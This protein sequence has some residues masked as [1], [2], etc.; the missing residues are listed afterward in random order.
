MRTL[1]T[2]W[3]IVV[4]IGLT[5]FSVSAAEPTNP[6]WYKRIYTELEDKRLFPLAKQL[7]DTEGFKVYP[8]KMGSGIVASDW[9]A[10]KSTKTGWQER[11][12]F[13]VHFRRHRVKKNTFQFTL[14]LVVEVLPPKATQWQNQRVDFYNHVFYRKTLDRMDE[15]VL[16]AG[17]KITRM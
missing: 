13:R 16:E 15:L 4:T 12:R 9:R 7:I 8:I 5:G 11:Q 17:G 2:A 6:N 14:D 1:M 3:L 10:I